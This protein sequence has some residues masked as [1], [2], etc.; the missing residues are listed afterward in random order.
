MLGGSGA[1]GVSLKLG[2]GLCD[3]Q[4]CEVVRLL[5]QHDAS[6]GESCARVAIL[7]KEPSQVSPHLDIG[8]VQ[9]QRLLQRGDH[10]FIRHEGHAN[11]RGGLTRSSLAIVRAPKE[12]QVGKE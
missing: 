7:M 3:A 2:R 10:R 8:W 6:F 1:D 12:K 4:R 9:G 5:G 11:P